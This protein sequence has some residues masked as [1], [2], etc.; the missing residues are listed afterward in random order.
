MGRRLA[1]AG[2]MVAFAASASAQ[3]VIAPTENLAFDRPE[4]WAQ[5]Y[6]TSVSFLTGL[7]A[8]TPERPGAVS[9]QL[10]SGWIPA[11]KPAQEQVGFAGTASE[12][13]NKAPIFFR[14][15]VRIALPG[16]FAVIAGGVPPVRAF[17]VTPRLAAVAVEWTM[18]ETEAWRVLWRLHGQ[19]GTVTGAF[20]CPD[21][22]LTSPAGAAGNP[23]GC[24][25]R[26]ADVATL[27]YGAIELE[28]ARRL[29]RLGDLAPH[30]AVAVNGI[31]SRF[32]VNARAFGRLDQ[33]LL[34]TRGVTLSIA[35]GAAIPIKSRIAVAADAF[36]T[37]LLVRRRSAAPRTVDGLFNIR[38]LI[39]YR[40]R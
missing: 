16:R 35:G 36:Y 14:P 28:T 24:E 3:P 17:G 9:V 15:R 31:D 38:A 25:A 8:A 6:F 39:S 18:T 4:A 2:V 37:P 34:D 26:S 13:L 5:Q 19:T 22:V 20:T 23:T 33:T 40:V 7:G 30:V 12:D 32:Q 29:D 11:L 27:R 21:A 1:M 10:E